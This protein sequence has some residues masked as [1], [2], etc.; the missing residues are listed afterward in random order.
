MSITPLAK[1]TFYGLLEEKE[2]V[3]TDI[4]EMGCVHLLPLRQTSDPSEVSGPSPAIRKALKF[5]LSCPERRHQILNPA[6][7][8]AAAVEARA[9]EIQTRIQLLTNERDHILHRNDQLMPWG[10]FKV[11]SPDDLGGFKVW[12]YIVPHYQMK[13]FPESDMV[14]K[15]INRDNRFRYVVIVAAEEPSNIQ[16]HQ[17]QI[18]DKSLSELKSRLEEVEVELEDLQAERVSLT[19]WLTLFIRSVNRLEDQAAR[20]NASQ[21]TFDSDPVFAVQGWAR[22]TIVPQLQSY[23]EAKRLALT[24]EEPAPEDEPPTL[25]DNPEPVAGGQDLVSFYMT[26]SYRM[27]DPSSVVFFSF[28]VFFAMIM[29]D[30]GYS[31]LL[32][33]ILA[34]VW[35][36]IGQSDTGRRLRTLFAVLVGVSL[37]WGILTGGY[38]G[39]SPPEGSMLATLKVLDIQ[40]AATMMPL[41][42]LIGAVH[43]IVANLG[44]AWIHRQSFQALAP[45]GWAVIIIGGCALWMG[46]QGIISEIFVSGGPWVMGAGLLLVLFFSSAKTHP[47]KRL[48]DGLVAL[49]SLTKAFGDV[50]SYLRLFALGLASASLALAFNDLA[51]QVA[52]SISGFGM[53]LALVILILGHGIN[54]VLAIMS[55]F[56][57][58]LRLNYIE[59]F[60][61]GL[62]EEGTVFRAFAKKE[63]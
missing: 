51:H 11:P 14:W 63:L 2:A 20:A 12:L 1:V 50:L 38:F 39:I 44:A 24:I 21:E 13:E 55:G 35:T 57:H 17:I 16:G 34:A 60:N 61:W 28:A 36:R 62:P 53:L 33:I 3:L 56:V 48:L 9:I 40:D 32:G 23:S 43:I 7:F 27:W 52:S 46:T 15:E 37:L 6:N 49:T 19:R 47:L 59:F 41:S 29:S 30:A 18:G 25:F 10:D 22:E 45:I 58:G 54:F 31:A 26:P 4:Q 8:D 5:L 42:I